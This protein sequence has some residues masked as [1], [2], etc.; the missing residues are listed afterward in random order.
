MP[1]YMGHGSWPGAAAGAVL[2]VHSASDGPH[3]FS[4]RLLNRQSHDVPQPGL[5]DV[6]PGLAS[7]RLY[8]SA[9]SVN[10]VHL[11]EV[12]Q[13]LLERDTLTALHLF[14]DK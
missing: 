1:D 4:G 3:G 11:L 6:V 13:F 5:R 2:V 14:F 9:E 12:A 10:V 8:L 7:R